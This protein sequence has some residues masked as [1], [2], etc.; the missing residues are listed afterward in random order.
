M[1]ACESARAPLPFKTNSPRDI[2]VV[3]GVITILLLRP[4]MSAGQV[5]QSTNEPAVK[6]S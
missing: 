3:V 6:T 4:G 5:S 1:P 2:L